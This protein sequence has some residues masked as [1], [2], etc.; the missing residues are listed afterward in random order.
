MACEECAMDL[1]GVKV[2]RAHFAF[3]ICAIMTLAN[4]IILYP[5]IQ[6]QKVSMEE[7]NAKIINFTNTYDCFARDRPV[8]NWS[9]YNGG[10]GQ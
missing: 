10:I 4:F 6:A 5:A 3:F 8:Y 7:C 1:F 9:V 2:N